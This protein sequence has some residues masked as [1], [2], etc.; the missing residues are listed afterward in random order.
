MR[1]KGKNLGWID[2]A[3]VF[4]ENIKHEL[5]EA[6]V[7]GMTTEQ[8]IFMLDIEAFVVAFLRRLHQEQETGLEKLFFDP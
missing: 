3:Q 4:F 5:C 8:G 7:L 6:P 2:E 1:N